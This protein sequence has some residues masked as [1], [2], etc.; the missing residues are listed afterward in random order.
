MHEKINLNTKTLFLLILLPILFFSCATNT[1]V[2]LNSPN[3][4]QLGTTILP[5]LAM[6]EKGFHPYLGVG[7]GMGQ[8]SL[9]N[10]AYHSNHIGINGGILYQTSLLRDWDVGLF[11][12]ISSKVEYSYI[13]FSPDSD[14]RK[15]ISKEQKELF[16]AHKNSLSSDLIL[17][18]GPM[19]KF[20]I[21]SFSLYGLG[22]IEY[23]NGDYFDY[24]SKLDN[25]GNYYNLS[26]NRFAYGYGYGYDICL[27]KTREWDY[28]I[29]IE[30]R[31]LLLNTQ[32]Y[33]SSE[34]NYDRHSTTGE[35]T[36]TTVPGGVDLKY[37]TGKIEYYADMRNI[38]TS[39]S[40]S[41]N[42][43]TI[44]LTYRW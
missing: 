10:N 29:N 15:L 44:T 30:V 36:T 38:R 31:Y 41:P 39:V 27:G 12:S 37:K 35:Y 24:R 23:E 3:H 17:R 18:T 21:G 25:I 5:S 4:T 16:N 14:S 13:T 28:G 43:L 11:S 26:T 20:K 2:L 9:F 1:P 32:S 6:P 40:F 8:P 22:A 42:D 19:F 7:L 34:I 33:N